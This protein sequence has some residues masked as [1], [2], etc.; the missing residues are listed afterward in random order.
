MAE[1]RARYHDTIE[2]FW[3]NGSLILE[4]IVGRSELHNQCYYLERALRPVSCMSSSFPVIRYI[5]SMQK[6]NN[7]NEVTKLI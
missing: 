4:T 1:T 6:N 2:I 5:L 3:A 7:N